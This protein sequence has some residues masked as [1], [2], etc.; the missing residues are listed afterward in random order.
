MGGALLSGKIDYTRGLDPATARKV[1]ETPG[2]SSTSFYQ[3]VIH[4]IWTNDQHKPFDDPR[5]RRGVALGVGR[6]GLGGG[7]EEM[8]PM[9]GGG[10]VFSFLEVVTPPAKLAEPPGGIPD[11]PGATHH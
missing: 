5:V 3:S 9:L 2:M 6:A 7:G 4:A 8:G 11:P 1:K 10:V